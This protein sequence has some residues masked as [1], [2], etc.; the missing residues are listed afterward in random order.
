MGAKGNHTSKYNA[1]LYKIGYGKGK[2]ILK[3][4][5]ISCLIEE[6]LEPKKIQTNM[7]SFLFF[8]N[9]SFK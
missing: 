7:S 9:I 2:I 4:A 3:F 5:P 8:F 1:G 6:I